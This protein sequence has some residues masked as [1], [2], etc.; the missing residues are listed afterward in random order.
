[1]QE[2]FGEIHVVGEVVNVQADDFILDTQGKVDFG[3]LQPISF[4][5]AL[6]SYRVL[7]KIVG[8]AFKDRIKL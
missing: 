8:K 4:D 6:R 2:A 1:M 5:S 3:K 7:G